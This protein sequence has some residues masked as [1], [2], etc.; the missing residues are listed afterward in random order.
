MYRLLRSALF[1]LDPETAHHLTLKSL[2]FL[3][4]S[5]LSNIVAQHPPDNPRT[6]MGLTFPNPVG[7][8]AGLDKNGDCIDCLL[9]TSDAADE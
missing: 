8:A 3:Y 9:Y 6:L 7:L 2:N 4:S 5:G 1:R